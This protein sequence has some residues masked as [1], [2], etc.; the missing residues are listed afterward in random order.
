M[1]HDVGDTDL[2]DALLH[3]LFILAVILYLFQTHKVAVLLISQ[4]LAI[5]FHDTR[6]SFT[7]LALI[8]KFL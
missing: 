4:K 2:L 7:N 8:G 3:F 5:S 6:T 1:V